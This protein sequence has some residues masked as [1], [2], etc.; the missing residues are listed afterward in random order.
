MEKVNFKNNTKLPINIISGNTKEIAIGAYSEDW[1]RLPVGA[2]DIII[3][4]S[5]DGYQ[6]R[7]E[8]HV[9]YVREG[10]NHVNI[11]IDKIFE[12]KYSIVS[13]V[14][15]LCFLIPSS[16]FNPVQWTIHLGFMSID[17][18]YIYWPLFISF[19]V[20]Y[21]FQ[22]IKMHKIMKSNPVL[23]NLK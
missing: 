7:K 1:F 8:S 23:F 5:L 15:V 18:V 19:F 13:L 22:T 20:F 6:S 11:Q 17:F 10:E 21:F 2:T 9:I 3:E 16:F 4:T 12:K 14:F